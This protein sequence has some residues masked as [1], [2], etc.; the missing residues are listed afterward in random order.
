M[1]DSQ[2]AKALTIA[3]HVRAFLHHR[4]REGL[5]LH[6]RAL[7]VNPNLAMAWA[8]SGAVFVYMGDVAEAE[9]RMTRYKKLSP[10]DPHAFFYD[11]VFIMIALLQRDFEKAVTV[12]R[13]VSELNLSFSSSCRFYLSA[14]GHLGRQ[15]EI[16]VVRDR[17]L[18]LEPEFS[19]GRFIEGSV[20]ERVG[21]RDV[22]A[23]G[24]RLA[25]IP[26]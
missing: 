21:D 5:S 6:D 26:E 1:L 16:E 24:L 9:R 22:V 23:E 7:M 17:L 25:G 4:W 15:E 13:A 18:L 3:G 20:F 10:L 19:I 12:G 8:M 14:L 2:D 11:T